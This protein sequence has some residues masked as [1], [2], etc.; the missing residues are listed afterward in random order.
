[1]SSEDLREWKTQ[2]NFEEHVLH[3]EKDPH[4]SLCYGD[5]KCIGCG[6]VATRTN[7]TLCQF[8]WYQA[9]GLE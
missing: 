2:D 4:C 1:M 8:C 7:N 3:Q 5:G 9:E 6:G